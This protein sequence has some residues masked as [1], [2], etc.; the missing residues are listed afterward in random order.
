[1]IGTTADGRRVKLVRGGPLFVSVVMDNQTILGIEFVEW[2]FVVRSPDGW[3]RAGAVEFT[4]DDD[5]EGQAL[6]EALKPE[7]PGK[8]GPVK[9][10]RGW[11]GWLDDTFPE[12]PLLLFWLPAMALLCAIVLAPWGILLG[13]LVFFTAEN[14]IDGGEASTWRWFGLGWFVWG[15]VGLA[16]GSRLF[17]DD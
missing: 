1:M 14:R 7:K 13:P 9:R 2:R 5:R 4:P 12:I 15:W 16:I 11:F 6:M 3:I 10:V 8:P 17:G